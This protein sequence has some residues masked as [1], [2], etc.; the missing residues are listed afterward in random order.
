MNAGLLREW[1]EKHFR[2]GLVLGTE[3]SECLKTACLR[4]KRLVLFGA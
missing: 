3:L 4:R 2:W 1:A